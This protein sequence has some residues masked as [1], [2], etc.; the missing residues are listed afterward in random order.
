MTGDKL[1]VTPQS[2][3]SCSVTTGPS[4][5]GGAMATNVAPI[6]HIR[7]D[8]AGRAWIDG[9][10]YSVLDIVLDHLAHGWSPE[11]IHFQH[12]GEVSLARIHAALSY[13]FDHQKDLDAQIEAELR[14]VAALRTRA[15][16]SPLAAR[17]KK[18]GLLS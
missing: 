7:L 18:Q 1:A 13:Y 6:N 2:L 4:R 17:L 5:T 14:E 8:E 10:S 11:E 16:P 12:Y 9:T 15:G 3:Y